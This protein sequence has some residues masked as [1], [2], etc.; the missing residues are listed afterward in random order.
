MSWEFTDHACRVCFGRVMERVNEAEEGERRLEY[1]CAE[2]G[3]TGFG[4]VRAVC[5]CGDDEAVGRVGRAA[6]GNRSL[7][8]ECVRNDHP[9]PEVPQQ[10]LV[11]QRHVERAPRERAMPAR[12]EVSGG[13]CYV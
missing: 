1:R 12:V 2:C 4:H 11:R 9:T 13:G 5:C 6:H 10:V 8:L 3:A 7:G